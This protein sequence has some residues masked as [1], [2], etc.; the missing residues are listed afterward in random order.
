MLLPVN[1]KQKFLTQQ[2]RKA[3]MGMIKAEIELVN[4]E[5]LMLARRHFIGEEEIKSIRVNMIVDT[6]SFYVCI[7]ES[8]QA[9]LQLPVVDV[10]KGELADGRRIDCPLVGPVEVRFKNKRCVIDA[11]VLP[12]ENEMLLGAIPLEDM[13]VY[14]DPK[15]QELVVWEDDSTVS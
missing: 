1:H 2:I 9:F 10:K 6:G 13:D 7:N 14:I 8:V 15:R 11:M 3:N 5:D 12:G 4:G